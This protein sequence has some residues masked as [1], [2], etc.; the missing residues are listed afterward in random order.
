MFGQIVFSIAEKPISLYQQ[1]TIYLSRL[2]KFENIHNCI[3]GLQDEY[4]RA[5]EWHNSFIHEL[6]I[7]STELNE[8]TLRDILVRMP[9]FTYLSVGYCEF[10]SDQVR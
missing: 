10:F 7:T 1:I 5:V 4:M 9:G 8:E 2:Q 6:D 3:T